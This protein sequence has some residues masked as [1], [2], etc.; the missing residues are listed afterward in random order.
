MGEVFYKKL[1]CPH[2]L[3]VFACPKKRKGWMVLIK[4][5]KMIK[6]TL[7]SV[8][9]FILMF[10]EFPIFAAFPFLKLDFSDLPCMLAALTF[11]PVS[12]ITC[13]FLKNLLN[14]TLEGTT[15][16]FVGELANFLVGSAYVGSASLIY[17]MFK[18]KKSAI[19]SLLL[20]T[21]IATIFAAFA[22]YFLL[23]P[24]FKM[25]QEARF[26]TI[27]NGIIPFNLIKYFIVSIIIFLTYKKLSPYLKK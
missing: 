7:L 18:T 26:P 22:N 10:I 19:I 11:G 5:N 21:I 15:T 13:E 2:F 16:S 8:I 4:L 9:A 23:L 20:G 12:G 24:F 14:A 17:K 27:I 1:F 25:P 6:V 3:G